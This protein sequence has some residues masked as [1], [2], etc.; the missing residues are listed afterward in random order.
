MYSAS[1]PLNL[2]TDSLN[3]ESIHKG[4]KMRSLKMP[5]MVMKNSL[6]K[7]LNSFFFFSVNPLPHHLHM[8]LPP[9]KLKMGV[10]SMKQKRRA[11]HQN[12]QQCQFTACG[13]MGKKRKWEFGNT[14]N[15]RCGVAAAEH[16]P[17]KSFVHVLVKVFWQDCQ[18][19]YKYRPSN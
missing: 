3:A 5:Q 17:H 10:S 4:M 6:T 13:G 15:W 8:T 7:S 11:W 16:A 19:N 9:C 1:T 14:E 18:L 12:R 2:V